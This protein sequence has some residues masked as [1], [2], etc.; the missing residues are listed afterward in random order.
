MRQT[1]LITTNATYLKQGSFFTTNTPRFYF[2]K[3]VSEKDKKT[4]KK[5]KE[6]EEVHSQFQGKDIDAIKSDFD[7]KLDDGLAKLSEAM[8]QIRSG[9]ASP[10]IFDHLEITAYGEKH[11]FTDLCQVI[12]KGSN[13]LLV[14][15]FDDAAKE[16]VIKALQ[17]VQDFDLNVTVEGKD[18]KV[19]LGTSKKEHVDAAMKQVKAASEEF[20]KEVK[21]IRHSIHDV[22]KKLDKILPKDETN[23]LTKDLEKICTGKEA[24][25]KKVIDAKEKEIK[26]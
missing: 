6:K 10:N 15:V 16:D 4:E 3:K 7:A 18:L 8:K 14:R 2:A 22:V 5:E 11:P 23:L 17:R 21:D 19:K 12:V 26:G 1:R 24:E 13:L 9:R 25:A 20:K